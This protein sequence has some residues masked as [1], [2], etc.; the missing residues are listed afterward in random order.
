MPKHEHTAKK[1]AGRTPRGDRIVPGRSGFRQPRD[2]ILIVCEGEQTEYLYFDVIRRSGVLTNITIR[3]VPGAGQTLELIQA[4][5]EQRRQQARN[6]DG[7]PYNEVWCV[8]DREGVHQ[9]ANFNAAIAL[10]Q[11]EGLRLAISNPCFEYWYLLHFRETSTYFADGN[12][13]YTALRHQHCMPDYTKNANVYSRLQ[14]H[15]MLA[16]ERAERLYDRHPE[17][18][19][20]DFPNPSTIVFRLIRKLFD[21]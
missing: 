15:T 9:P 13:V 18:D 11:R 16:V 8:F 12:A 6:R 21:M 10:A 14:P 2:L 1:L 3:I 5:L 4:A 7:L 20:D 17:R 19:Q